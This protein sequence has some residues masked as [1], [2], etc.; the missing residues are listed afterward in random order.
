MRLWDHSSSVDGCRSA[1]SIIARVDT[2]ITQ[3]AVSACTSVT[4]MCGAIATLAG[5]VV[6][7]TLSQTLNTHNDSSSY[8]EWPVGHTLTS[9][10][11]YSSGAGLLARLHLSPHLLLL[12]LL[13]PG[14]DKPGSM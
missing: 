2:V 10:R 13:L 8:L 12:L 11:H 4:S 3:T 5:R 14:S 6:S 1:T 9:Y 7:V